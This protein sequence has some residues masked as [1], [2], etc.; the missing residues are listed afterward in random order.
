MVSLPI[1]IPTEGKALEPPPLHH[2]RSGSIAPT[3]SSRCLRMP[4]HHR[5]RLLP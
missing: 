3:S 2:G 4:T 1:K 5:K